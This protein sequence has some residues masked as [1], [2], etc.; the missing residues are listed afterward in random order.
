MSDELTAQDGI[1]HLPDSH[2]IL[3]KA[4]HETYMPISHCMSIGSR[5]SADHQES[6][7]KRSSLLRM[8]LPRTESAWLSS[9]DLLSVRIGA[10]ADVRIFQPC[11]AHAWEAVRR[12]NILT[13]LEAVC[14]SP[15]SKIAPTSVPSAPPDISPCGHTPVAQAE[16]DV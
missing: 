2:N 14:C 7:A 9:Y 6:K 13:T 8:A 1:L 3:V 16:G 10:V 15:S 11:H 4:T 12:C 5:G